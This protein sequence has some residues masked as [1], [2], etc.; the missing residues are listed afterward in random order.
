[1][2]ADSGADRRSV[3][4]IT[5]TIRNLRCGVEEVCRRALAGLR[6]HGT[7]IDRLVEAGSEVNPALLAGL[8]HG[9][10]LVPIGCLEVLEVVGSRD[11]DR[12]IPAFGA[13]LRKPLLRTHQ[14][15]AA[16]RALDAIDSQAPGPTRALHP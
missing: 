6:H 3:A 16:R 14:K 4:F 15:E 10:P 13:F 1:M 12:P 11:W 2:R 8:E 5:S 9:N 7:V